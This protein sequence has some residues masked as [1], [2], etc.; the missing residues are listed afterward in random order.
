MRALGAEIIRTPTSATFDSPESHISVA[1]R[2]NKQLPNSII[3][4]QVISVVRSPFQFCSK[5]HPQV[6]SWFF[7]STV[8]LAT[9]WLIMTLLQKKLLNSVV[10][11][12]TWLFLELE[13]VE[14]FVVKI[15]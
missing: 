11:K 8:T 1:Q 12:W 3:L 6:T 10:E 7:C 2:I 9:L 15:L 4:D 14:L 13:L 5:Q